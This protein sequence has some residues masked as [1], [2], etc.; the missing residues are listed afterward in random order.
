MTYNETTS[1]ARRK[2]F[3][4]IAYILTGIFLILLLILYLLYLSAQRLPDFYKKN[5]AVGEEIQ[6]LRNKEMR[7]KIGHLNNA[8]QKVGESWQAFFTAE[9]LNAYFAVE[10]AQEGANLFPNEITEPCLTFS[11]RQVDFACRITQGSF[12]GILHL[13][14]GLTLPEPNR[15]M[16]R[17]K[18]AKLGRLPISKE[19]PVKF[20]VQAFEEK[21]YQVQQG[22]ESGDPVITV[23]LD[24]QYGKNCLVLLDGIIFQDGTVHLSG[25]TE[26]PN[27]D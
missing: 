10:L 14:L 8:F 4:L 23:I 9:D 22:K 2:I 26:L 1:S 13:T 12:S 16:I 11:D 21:S 7:Y 3:R 25:T 17:I 19:I 24:M 5:L 20:L 27:K 15:L 18:N 6:Q